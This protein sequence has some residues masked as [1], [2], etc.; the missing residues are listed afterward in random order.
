MWLKDG[1][2]VD[3]RIEYPGCYNTGKSPAAL[4]WGDYYYVGFSGDVTSPLSEA[5][6]ET[7]KDNT[8]RRKFRGDYG[9]IY[10]YRSM[11]AARDKYN[12][13]R[14]EAIAQHNAVVEKVR[15]LRKR[16][17]NGDIAAALELGD[18]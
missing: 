12:A 18:Y 11:R 5:F 14:A 15:S 4:H 8:G 1:R 10:R 13:L 16:A 2:F 17:A 7:W 3:S 6:F 9:P